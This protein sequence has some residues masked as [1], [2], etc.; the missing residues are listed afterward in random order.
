MCMR[1]NLVYKNKDTG[2]VKFLG[3]YNRILEET[4][5]KKPKLDYDNFVIVPCGKCPECR[6]KWRRQLAERVRYELI[7]RKS[8]A[9]F[10][11]LTYNNDNLP[12]DGSLVHR[13]VQLFMKR[14]RRQL[15]YYYMTRVRA[16]IC[17]EYGHKNGRPHYHLI[18]FGVNHDMLEQFGKSYY[19]RKSKKGHTQYRNPWLE[20]CWSK[21][22]RVLGDNG[23]WHTELQPLGFVEVGDVL[24]TSAPYMA[25][26]MVKYSDISKDEFE[27]KTG[28]LK[29][30]YIVY[31]AEMLGKDYFLKHFEEILMRGYILD[32]AGNCVGV[33]RSFLNCCASYEETWDCLELYYTN[34]QNAIQKELD[35]Y[36]SRGYTYF[37]MYEEKFKKGEEKEEIYWSKKG[38]KLL[39]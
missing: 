19:W 21:K 2:E 32:S 35:D 33:P 20:K 16:F 34:V 26:Y 5:C 7:T 11:T 14:L 23:K 39:G 4:R 24:D 9:M 31:P 3:N 27:E 10:I 6:Q 17:G 36:R 18:V 1:P 38:G 30:P 25:K 29:K 15:E 28:G 8:R 37:E 22:I 12:A 13:D